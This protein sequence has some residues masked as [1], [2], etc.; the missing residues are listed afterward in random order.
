MAKELTAKASEFL[1]GQQFAVLATINPDGTAQQTVMWYELRD[2]MII[3]NTT[4]TRIK[5]QNLRRDAR[6]SVCV[7]DG[8][9]FVTIAGTAQLNDD[10]ATAQADILRL[11]IRYHGEE[12]G[13]KQA[14]MFSKQDRVSIYLPIE[15]IVIYG[16][17][18]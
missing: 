10:V 18:D 16:F 14:E 1:G 13:A 7:A 11:A 12:K 4:K 15:R 8:Y 2:N 5:G 6:I 17:D 3:M 9:R